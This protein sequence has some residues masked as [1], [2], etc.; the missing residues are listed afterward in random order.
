MHRLLDEFGGVKPEQLSGG[1]IYEGGHAVAIQSIDA[2]PC[3]REDDFV[4]TAE[5][6]ENFL[7]PATLGD[8]ANDAAEENRDIG[9]PHG[10]RQLDR[11]LAAVL[12]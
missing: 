12:A 2:F 4:Q 3:L 8:V 1:R 10:Q 7:R 9:A 6:V 11:E 5:A